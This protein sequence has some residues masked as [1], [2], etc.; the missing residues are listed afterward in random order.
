MKYSIVAMEYRKSVDFV[1]ALAVGAEVVLLREPNNPH[2]K[3]AVAVWV[4]DRHV[5]YIPKKQ[6][7]ALANRIDAAGTDTM[8]NTPL[9]AD[10][11]LSERTEI[12]K[13]IPAKFVRSP[14]SGYPMVEVSE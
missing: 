4:G 5:G 3:F 2:D 6:N 13:S 8:L 7:V 10:A 14:N 1:A 9:A 11:E 12:V